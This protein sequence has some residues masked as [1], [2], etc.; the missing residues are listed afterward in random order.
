MELRNKKYNINRH[1]LSEDCSLKAFSAADEYLIK[2]YSDLDKNS[3]TLAIYNDRFGFLTCH[4]HSYHPTT[5]ITNKSQEKAIHLNLEANGIETPN[6]LFPLSD[7][8]VKASIVLMKVPKSLALFELFLNQ[9]VQNSTEDLVVVCAFMTRHFSPKLLQIAATY[10]DD[11][12]QSRALKKARLLTL[13]QK[14]VVDASKKLVTLTH[15]GKKY[16]QYYG[17][18]SAD[19]IDYA[20]QFFLNHLKIEENDQYI[21]DLASGNGVIAAKIHTLLPDAEIHLLDDSY[22]AIASSQLNL[23]G[24]KIHHHFDNKLSA[25]ENNSFDLIVSNPP[26]HFEYEINILIPLQL[27]KE[28][29]RCLKPAGSFQLV[30]NNHLNYKV[31]L[32]KLFRRVDI[33]AENE[34]FVVYNCIK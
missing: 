15:E 12:Q 3:K 9:I 29:A 31:H 4:L 30:A 6:F 28:C 5:I 7:F 20:T 23:Q 10:F 8:K 16:L 22:L 17:V 34:K 24:K 2:A 11:V 18:F 33:I 21:L 19:H 25:F 1:D 26:F 27:F 13:S 32:S 14:R